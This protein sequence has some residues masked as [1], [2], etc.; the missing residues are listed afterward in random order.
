MS[1]LSAAVSGAWKVGAIAALLV[2]AG[3][4]AGWALA[5]H[6]RD[7][8]RADLRTAQDENKG[9]AGAIHDQN[10]AVAGLAA[11]TQEA[12]DKRVVAEKAAA[13][14][15]ARGTSRAAAVSAS[16]APDC[17][18]VLNEAWGAWK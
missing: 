4:G 14:A 2:A 10:I 11:K 9:L 1:I 8:A 18:G 7:V 3:A 6:D 13:A 17:A 5:A 15:I 12:V 16:S